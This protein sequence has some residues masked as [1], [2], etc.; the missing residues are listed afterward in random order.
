[1]AT[2]T[3]YVPEKD[4]IEIALDTIEQVSIGRGP[5][6]DVVIDDVSM[7]GSH[8]VIRNLGG[9]YQITDLDSTNGSFLNGDALTEEVLSHGD[10]VK[11]GNIESVYAEADTEEA[12]AQESAPM[13]TADDYTGGGGHAAAIAEVSN[14]P[15]GFKD[16]SP[17][18]KV[19]KKDTVG[20]I[21]MIVGV[22]AIVAAIVVVAMSATMKAV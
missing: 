21:A 2:F 22:V 12:P 15:L 17:I 19:V 7:S 4:P 8:A 6:N 9:T 10:R 1:M 3:I 18:E 5:D 13:E 16:L 20:Q 11:F 14:C